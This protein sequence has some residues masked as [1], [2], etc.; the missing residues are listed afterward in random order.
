MDNRVRLRLRWRCARPFPQ[1]HCCIELRGQTGSG[2]KARS[3]SR[4]EAVTVRRTLRIIRLQRKIPGESRVLDFLSL[5]SDEWYGLLVD[6]DAEY[7]ACALHGKAAYSRIV[8]TFGDCSSSATSISAG[9]KVRSVSVRPESAGQRFRCYAFRSARGKKYTLMLINV[10]R[11]AT[12]MAS[13]DNEEW[14]EFKRLITDSLERAR[15]SRSLTER[16]SLF[17]WF[18]GQ[19]SA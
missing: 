13:V 2:G 10:N 1:F 14:P 12:Y 19:I 18:S 5:Q 11:Q 15:P 16:L 17:S 6:V 7:D 9:E 4:S 8:A 3:F